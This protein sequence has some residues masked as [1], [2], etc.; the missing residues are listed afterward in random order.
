MSR[1]QTLAWKVGSLCAIYLSLSSL[2]LYDVELIYKYLFSNALINWEAMD[3]TQI[4]KQIKLPCF[5]YTFLLSEMK[6]I[7]LSTSG[8]ITE[9]GHS[10]DRDRTYQQGS[11]V[12]FTLPPLTV[13][14]IMD[15]SLIRISSKRLNKR[16]KPWV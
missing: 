13:L 10:K 7:Y 4:Q 6:F 16:C 2:S 15:L 5:M 1:S 3:Y 14:Q 8:I 9:F 11:Q 12:F